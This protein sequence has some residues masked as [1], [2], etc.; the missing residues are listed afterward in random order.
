ML[1]YSYML[2]SSWREGDSG[3]GRHLVI[4]VIWIK[5]WCK[6]KRTKTGEWLI[7]YI[8]HIL[9][10]RISSTPFLY[11]RKVVLVWCNLNA[12]LFWTLQ[13]EVAPVCVFW[14]D[15]DP[16]SDPF[17]NVL[18]WTQSGWENSPR[19]N[20]LK[21]CLFSA[22][23]KARMCIKITIITFKKGFQTRNQLIPYFKSN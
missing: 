11:V 6:M 15:T 21:T 8:Q 23:G 20:K 19:G 14:L 1:T 4:K 18:K 12:I 2:T 17:I 10:M 5:V 3:T 22:S 7:K 16:T 9:Y 13:P